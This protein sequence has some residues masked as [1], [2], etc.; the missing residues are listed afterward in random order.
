MKTSCFQVHAEAARKQPVIAEEARPASETKHDLPRMDRNILRGFDA[1][2][3]HCRYTVYFKA[4]ALFACIR[5]RFLNQ[6]N[7]VDLIYIC[8]CL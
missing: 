6:N 3:R 8:Y 1:N 5:E 7:T 2:G 4:Y